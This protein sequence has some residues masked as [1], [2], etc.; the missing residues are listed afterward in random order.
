MTLGTW[1]IPA[2][3]RLTTALKSIE[4][5]KRTYSGTLRQEILAQKHNHTLEIPIQ[6]GTSFD[7]LKTMKEADENV[8]FVYPDESGLG[9]ITQTVSI[10]DL[11][12]IRMK[13][14][15]LGMYIDKISLTLEEV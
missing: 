4:T 2:G 1:T 6:V 10:G 15:P 5:S 11:N 13:E 9:D 7:D 8:S 12:Y 14:Y 3:T